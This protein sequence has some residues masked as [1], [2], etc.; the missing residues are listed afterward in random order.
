M[1]R[2]YLPCEDDFDLFTMWFFL[3]KKCS[4]DFSWAFLFLLSLITN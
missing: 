4:R 2:L 3:H 1:N